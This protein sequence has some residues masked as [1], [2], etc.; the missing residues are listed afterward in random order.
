MRWQILTLCCWTLLSAL[1]SHAIAQDYYG[2]QVLDSQTARGVP[3]VKL[4]ADN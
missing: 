1:G 2:I 4:S 3:L